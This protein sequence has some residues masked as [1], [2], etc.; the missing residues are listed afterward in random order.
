[1]YH[2]FI[3]LFTWGFLALHL[4]MNSDFIS[5]HLGVEDSCVGS[6]QGEIHKK[7]AH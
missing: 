1:M 5:K 6:K 2:V 3:L 7:R 4:S